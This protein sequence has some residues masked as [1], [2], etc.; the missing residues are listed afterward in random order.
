MVLVESHRPIEISKGKLVAKTGVDILNTPGSVEFVSILVVVRRGWA[1]GRWHNMFRLAVGQRTV[2][3]EAATRL[4][5]LA[6]RRFAGRPTRLICC[7]CVVH[8]CRQTKEAIQP[9]RLCLEEGQMLNKMRGY[10]GK[11]G[12]W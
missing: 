10:S 12:L 5:L 3:C 7:I 11:D 6:P 2:P 9:R 8:H 1:S 4:R